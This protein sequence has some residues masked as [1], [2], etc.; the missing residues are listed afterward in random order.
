MCRRG[1]CLTVDTSALLTKG[2]REARP[3][4]QQICWIVQSTELLVLGLCEEGSAARFLGIT[5]VSER[6]DLGISKELMAVESSAG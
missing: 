1:T 3:E 4:T 5:K 2:G 6:E